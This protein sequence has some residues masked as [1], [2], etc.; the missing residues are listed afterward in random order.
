MYEKYVRMDQ[1]VCVCR[2]MIIVFANL[3]GRDDWSHWIV[4]EEKIRQIFQNFYHP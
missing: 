2:S 1:C 3:N 4:L